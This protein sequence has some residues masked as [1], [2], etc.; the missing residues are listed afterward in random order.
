MVSAFNIRTCVLVDDV[1][2][3]TD[4]STGESRGFGF[5]LFKEEASIDEVI[6]NG[7][8]N[9]GYVSNKIASNQLYT[10]VRS[11]QPP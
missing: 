3:K 10:G 8:H 6:N 4:P 7:P 2:I 5:L 1:D 11:L 9:L